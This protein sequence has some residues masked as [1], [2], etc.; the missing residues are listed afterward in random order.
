MARNVGGFAHDL[1]ALSELQAE[2]LKADTKECVERL[3][4]PIVLL[5]GAAVLAIGCVPVAL[6][7][8]AFGLVT[9]G[10][11]N[12]LAFL[13]AAAAGVGLATLVGFVGWRKLCKSPV[14]FERSKDEF[15]SNFRWV[16]RVLTNTTM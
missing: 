13:L 3:I 12:W 5:A 4:M 8:L 7:A 1:L 9:A 2:L 6:A 16:K 14:V 11:S 15:S 10:L